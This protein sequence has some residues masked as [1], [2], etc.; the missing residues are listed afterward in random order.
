MN[1]K[2]IRELIMTDYVDG[3]AGPKLEREIRKHLAG[4]GSCREFEIA[5]KKKAIEPFKNA[6]KL[7]APDT[8]WDNVREAITAPQAT[9]V[10]IIR[11]P[12]F[13]LALAAVTVILIAVFTMPFFTA[14]RPVA[15]YIEEQAEFFAYL[16][17]GESGFMNEEDEGLGT[18]IEEY[19]L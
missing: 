9:P 8:I 13:S 7:E 6:G 16:D 14:P 19:F 5:L 2:K 3:E 15:G 10:F 4:C 1:C 17:N 12:A 18:A 11:R